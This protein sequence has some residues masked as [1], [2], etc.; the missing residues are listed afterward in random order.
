MKA[1]TW[2]FLAGLAASTLTT[3]WLGPI[4][5]TR[6]SIAFNVALL[7]VSIWN[8]MSADMRAEKES[9]HG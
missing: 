4:E 5:H 3:A 7:V 6:A 8:S 1:S 9:P 2:A